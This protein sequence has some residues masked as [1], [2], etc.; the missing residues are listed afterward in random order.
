MKKSIIRFLQEKN[1][2]AG[3]VVSCV[4]SLTNYGLRFAN[5]EDGTSGQG[6]FEIMSLCGTLSVQG[7]HLHLSI[8]DSTGK[9]T[10]GHLLD[11]CLIYT[12][13][14]IVIGC[15]GQ[16]EFTRLVDGTTPWKELQI[17]EIEDLES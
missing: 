5:R 14:E 3:W 1:I 7:C 11:G 16:M 13:A 10:G 2:R 17:K 15:T 9:V 8:A 4:G 6:Y 12:T